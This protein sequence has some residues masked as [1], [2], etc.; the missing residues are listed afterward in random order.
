MFFKPPDCFVSIEGDNLLPSVKEIITWITFIAG[1]AIVAVG[2]GLTFVVDQNWIILEIVGWAIA[3]AIPLLLNRKPKNVPVQ[4][5]NS[6][7]S[8]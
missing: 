1:M 7:L 5:P 8:N 4:S 3:I 2:A 6:G